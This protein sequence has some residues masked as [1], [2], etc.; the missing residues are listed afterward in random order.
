MVSMVSSG[1]HTV[2]I[3]SSKIRKNMVIR[4]FLDINNIVVI[5]QL[6]PLVFT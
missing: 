6:R 1:F 2:T 5:K 4:F 3:I